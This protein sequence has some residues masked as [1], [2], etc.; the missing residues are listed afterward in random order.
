MR[1]NKKGGKRETRVKYFDMLS[2]YFKDITLSIYVKLLE[3]IHTKNSTL[4]FSTTWIFFNS[5]QKIYILQWWLSLIGGI[6]NQLGIYL[7]HSR[8]MDELLF[9]MPSS[10]VLAKK[11]RAFC[12]HTWIPEHQSALLKFAKDFQVVEHPTEAQCKPHTEFTASI[13]QSKRKQ[14]NFN[15]IFI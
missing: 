12:I 15:D 3:H 13:S 11:P 14:V 4:N 1:K 10:R 8:V 5:R 6:N 2:I 9:T 7:R